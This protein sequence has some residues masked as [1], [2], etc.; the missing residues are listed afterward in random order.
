MANN[1]MTPDEFTDEMIRIRNECCDDPEIK[2]REM[3]DFMC[4]LLVNLGYEEG[5]DIFLDAVSEVLDEESRIE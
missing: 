5:V 3:Q 2:Y 1:Y 4:D